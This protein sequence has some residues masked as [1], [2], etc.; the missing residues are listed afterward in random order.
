MPDN[1]GAAMVRHG[2]LTYPLESRRFDDVWCGWLWLAGSRRSDKLRF[3]VSGGFL[4][5]PGGR[6]RLA[7]V[8]VRVRGRGRRP[9]RR[10]MDASRRRPPLVHWARRRNGR[11]TMR[12]LFVIVLGIAAG[13]SLVK[14]AKSADKAAPV[15]KL[16]AS[17]YDQFAEPW[18]TRFTEAWTRAVA[19]AKTASTRAGTPSTRAKTPETPAARQK[20]MS[21]AKTRLAELETN[22]PPFIPAMPH[23]D[24]HVG[25]CGSL[26]TPAMLASQII[27][28]DTILITDYLGMT[29]ML[30]GFSTAGLVDGR[31]FSPNRP[32]IVTGTT[33][34][35][36][37]AGST[38]TVL[39]VQPFH[40]E[41]A[42]GLA[43]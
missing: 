13:F 7:R 27:D 26:P 43:K 37:A 28:K 4:T 14:P 17:A 6:T 42:S 39:L 10:S 34:Y 24:W 41:D 36:T 2:G 32:L 1:L 31:T 15:E 9:G 25:D 11:Q 40:P 30:K 12:Y 3:R 19:S 35:A 18:K 21:D 8:R 5:A 33:R 38:K 16:G 23:G 20:R 22:D 29:L